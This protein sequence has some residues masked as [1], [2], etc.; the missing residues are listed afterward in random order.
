MNGCGGDKTIEIVSVPGTAGVNGLNAYTTISSNFIVPAVGAN[1]TV[2]VANNQ[3]FVPGQIVIAAGPA[4]SPPTPANFVVVSVPTTLPASVVLQFLGY[5]GD[6]APGTTISLGASLSPAGLEGVGQ[7]GYTQTT[8]SQTVLA[9]T[10]NYSVLNTG[11]FV[12]GEYVIMAATGGSANFLVS[13]VVNGTTLALTFLNY[14]GNVSAG[15]AIPPNS[16]VAPAGSAGQNAYTNFISSTAGSGSNTVPSAAG[17]TMTAVVGSTAWMVV[18]QNIVLGSTTSGFGPATFQ[19]TSITNSTT[20]VLTWLD[21]INDVAGGSAIPGGTGFSPA[22]TQPISGTNEASY[23]SGSNGVVLTGT[24]S[25]ITFG[26]TAIQITLPT[27]GTW[28]ISAVVV[29]DGTIG[30]ASSH[31][32]GAIT[33]L[34]QRTNNTA[35]PLSNSSNTINF[36]RDPTQ[37]TYALDIEPVIASFIYT[38]TTAGDIIQIYASETQVTGSNYTT[39]LQASLTAF[40]I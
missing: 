11:S 30:A 40:Q 5:P 37:T 31:Q 29:Y 22:G 19:V 9:G 21:Y 36:N 23:L 6:V 15:T 32:A 2:L 4:G 25:P 34:L 27:A 33:T 20:V 12:A 38:T 39:P 24:P 13:S 35:A 7:N 18:G 3:W 26:S 17:D 14:I 1:V 16:T 8:G 10:N 28:V